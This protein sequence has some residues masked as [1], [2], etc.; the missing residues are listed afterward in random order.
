MH[1]IEGTP[2]LLYSTSNLAS[3]LVN[4]SVKS[5]PKLWHIV[6]FSIEIFHLSAK[7]SKLGLKLSHMI[8]DWKELLH[9]RLIM[10]L[11]RCIWTE[12]LV[13]QKSLQSTSEEAAFQSPFDL[14]STIHTI[15]DISYP[16]GH[17]HGNSDCMFMTEKCTWNWDEMVKCK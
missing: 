7:I 17:H 1:S 16:I 14:T 5:V 11:N 15:K 2:V 13:T 3:Q 10:E 8:L 4:R 9:I 12:D 6:Y